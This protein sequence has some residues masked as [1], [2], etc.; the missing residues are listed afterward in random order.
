[1]IMLQMRYIGFKRL[2]WKS[3]VHNPER[4]AKRSSSKYDWVFAG[5][6]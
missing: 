3:Q 2:S 6:K 4:Q 5:A 1:M